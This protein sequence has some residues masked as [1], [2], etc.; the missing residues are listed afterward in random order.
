[1]TQQ[2]KS[3]ADLHNFVK[4]FYQNHATAL[5]GI[6][7]KLPEN[8]RAELSGLRDS[9]NSSLAKLPP[10][11]QVPVAQDAAWAF[12]SF[13]D[14]I[15]RMQEY[16]NGLLEKMNSLKTELSSKALAL[17]GLQDQITKGDLLSKEKSKEA[18]DLARAEGA[19]TMKPEIVATRKSAL[20]LAGLPVP[21]D[22]VLSLPADQ[23]GPRAEAAKTNVGK[24]A[25][26]GLK[27]GGRG[28][29]WVKQLAWLGATEFAGQLTALDE[30][31]GAGPRSDTRPDPLLGNPGAENKPGEGKG[32][33]LT[34][35]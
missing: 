27:V 6:I 19:N 34:L 20:E 15:V 22:E 12:N 5:N 13:A 9:L 24:L 35:A 25:E 30:L 16:A 33:S 23:Y 21:G 14:A 11:E 26:K 4:S 7:D 10:L 28:A 31:I 32:V 8:L 3:N 2:I 18:C 29:A 17:N 1:M